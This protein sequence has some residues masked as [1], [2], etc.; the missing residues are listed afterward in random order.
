MVLI[1]AFSIVTFRSTISADAVVGLAAAVVVILSVL[2]TRL[3]YI[4][5]GRQW[6][7]VPV[8]GFRSSKYL[9]LPCI[10]FDLKIFDRRSLIEA[11]HKDHG[12]NLDANCAYI[13]NSSL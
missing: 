7:H 12:P 6:R 5:F 13:S 4:R 10:W 1:S 11:L 9:H 8:A 2:Y 3:Y